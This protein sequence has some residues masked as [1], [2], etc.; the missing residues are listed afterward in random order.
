MH[1]S[2]KR[3]NQISGKNSNKENLKVVKILCQIYQEIMKAS[4]TNQS[5]CK[6]LQLMWT[7]LVRI[8][9]GQS[10]SVFVYGFVFQVISEKTLSSK[11]FTRNFR[12]ILCENISN[13]NSYKFTYKFDLIPVLSFCRNQK[14]ESK[15]QQVGDLKTRNISAFCL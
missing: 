5:S 10:T 4:K 11:D 7:L 2:C 14:V 6:A 9:R 1:C 8:C 15:F 12:G 3:E 13:F